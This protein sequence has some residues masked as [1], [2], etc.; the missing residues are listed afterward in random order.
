MPASMEVVIV[1]PQRRWATITHSLGHRQS[2]QAT[3]SKFERA[4]VEALSPKEIIERDFAIFGLEVPLAV[5]PEQ[6]GDD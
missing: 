6:I 5:Q 1:V 3:R 2:N 4:R